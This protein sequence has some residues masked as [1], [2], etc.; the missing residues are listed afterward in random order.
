MAKVHSTVFNKST[1]NA[2]GC[3]SDVL[4][5]YCFQ[6]AHIEILLRFV[7]PLVSDHT[8]LSYVF[9]SLSRY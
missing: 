5:P 2:V 9:N 7:I 1:L 8:F 6:I 3:Q 4:L